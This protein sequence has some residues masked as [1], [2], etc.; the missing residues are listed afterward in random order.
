MGQSMTKEAQ[1]NAVDPIGW[2]SSGT[3]LETGF[4]MGL[5]GAASGLGFSAIHRAIRLQGGNNQ[6]VS[7]IKP[8]LV[9]SI[10]GSALGLANSLSARRSTPT[11]N[12]TSWP[13][14]AQRIE[15]QYYGGM[16]MNYEKY[17]GL[18]Y[19]VDKQAM[20][21]EAIAPLLLAAL[22]MAGKLLMGGLAAYGGY[23]AVREGMKGNWLGAA[24]N[25]LMAIP[26]IG[27]LGRGVKGLQM[28]GRLGQGGKLMAPSN[29]FA[30]AGKYTP[31]FYTAGKQHLANWGSD[32]YNVLGRTKPVQ[33]LAGNTAVGRAAG[34]AENLGNRL[35]GW[36]PQLLGGGGLMMAGG[37]PGPQQMPRRPPLQ[38]A[39]AQQPNRFA[40]LQSMFQPQAMP[41]FSQAFGGGG[42]V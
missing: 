42:V 3:P 16:P 2:A 22:P 23:G 29:M 38:M 20:D 17:A 33:A 36:K 6:P 21:K 34:M 14:L 15:A 18:H 5:V 41:Q 12:V 27:M 24:G 10:I 8:M 40:G 32:I 31:E 19:I 13:E 7:V 28:A 30:S 35:G 1:Y 39:A 9:G 37:M 26:G 11:S 25:A 4:K